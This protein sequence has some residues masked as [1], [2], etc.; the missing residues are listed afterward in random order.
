MCSSLLA[1]V[2]VNGSSVIQFAHFSVKEYLTSNRLAESKETISQFHV[3]MT[4]AHTIVAQAC[5]GV[6]LHMDERITN[7]D[8]GRFPL[9]MYAAKHWVGHAQSQ[10]VSPK[11]QDGTKR[12]FDPYN[13]HLSIS[14]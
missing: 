13:H 9:A 3:S 4:Q 1:I 10:N 7:D 6:L 12:I 2:D 14:S 8:L 11:L 5:L